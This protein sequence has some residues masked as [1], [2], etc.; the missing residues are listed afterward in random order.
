M[1]VVRW[2]RGGGDPNG[3]RMVVGRPAECPAPLARRSEALSTLNFAGVPQLRRAHAAEARD[4]AH[5]GGH[6]RAAAGVGRARRVRGPQAGAS[7]VDGGARVN[8]EGGDTPFGPGQE[9]ERLGQCGA[10]GPAVFTAELQVVAVVGDLL[11]RRIRACW[12]CSSVAAASSA[13]NRGMRP[14][15]KSARRSGK[16]PVQG[17]C[18]GCGRRSG[19]GTRTT[20]P[21]GPCESEGSLS[22][23]AL[24]TRGSIHAGRPRPE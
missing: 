14:V 11:Q 3:D 15:R 1:R 9:R 18:S 13:M 2:A 21:N 10:G 6:S 4:A 7:L 12:S 23:G 22:G 19:V 20:R 8:P 17:A 5:A 16:A 24:F